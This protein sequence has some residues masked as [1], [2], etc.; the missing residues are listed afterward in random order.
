M[1][2]A[3]LH[4]HTTYSWDGTCTVQGVLKQASQIAGLDVIAITDHDVI[5]GAYRAREI[6]SKYNIDVV[7]GME[8][9]S[10]DGHILCLFLQHAVPAGLTLEDT[11]RLVGEQGGVCIAA[12]PTARG[13]SS[14]SEIRLAQALQYPEVAAVLVGLETFNAGL[15]YQK[16][17]RVAHGLAKRYHL[18]GTGNSDAH[19]SWMI[20]MGASLFPGKT[21]A[22]LKQSLI[23]RQTREI[24]AG[25][26]SS[27]HCVCSWLARYSL[28]KLGWVTSNHAPQFPLITSRLAN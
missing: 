26:P 27:F 6:A 15:V 7:V 9:T 18:A 23:M 14:I 1:G 2:S 21:A 20:G 4:V 16:S 13:V 12:H 10:L 24:Y 28:R 3:D 5:E 11:V 22:E 19:V 25:K 8:V 17:N